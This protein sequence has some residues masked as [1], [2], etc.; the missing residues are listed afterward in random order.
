NLYS[1]MGGHPSNLVSEI[2]YATAPLLLLAFLVALPWGMAHDWQ[3]FALRAAIA[4]GLWHWLY[5]RELAHNQFPIRLLGY[6][7]PGKFLYAGVLW[8][9][10]RSHQKGLLAWKGREYPVGT[11]GASKS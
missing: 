9:S 1:L 3:S 7:I 2:A 5:S 6:G 10:F 8:A 11:S 4:L